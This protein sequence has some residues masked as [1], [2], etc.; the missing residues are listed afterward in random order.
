MTEIQE[1]FK[2]HASPAEPSRHK[3]C[4]KQTERQMTMDWPLCGSLCMPVEQQDLLKV[5]E[6]Q[7]LG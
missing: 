1:C 4:D 5:T 2:E 6:R 3:K 7:L